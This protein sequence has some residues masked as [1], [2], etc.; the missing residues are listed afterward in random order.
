HIELMTVLAPGAAPVLADSG[1]LQ[2]LIMNLAVNA[3][4]AM[5]R[6]GRLTIETKPAQLDEAF[7]R[8]VPDA[9]PGEYV[10]LSVADS[11]VGMTPE[12]MAHIFEPFFTTKEIGKGTGLGLATVYGI[13]RQSGGLI[14]GESAV[15]RGTTF[16]IHLP[17]VGTHAASVPGARV[18]G[19]RAAAVVSPSAVA[20]TVML[21]EDETRVRH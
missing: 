11:G 3:R 1:Q 7:T 20:A 17:R 15:G 10:C 19:A 14:D 12:T 18:S 6:G 2:Q 9:Q 5:S 8:G 21:V 13:V 16:R 4:D